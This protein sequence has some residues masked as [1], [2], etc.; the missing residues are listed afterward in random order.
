[1][2]ARQLECGLNA[3]P[4]SSVGRLFDAVASLLGVRQRARYEAQA[5]MELEALADPAAGGFYPLAIAG[6][7]PAVL[8]PAP[9]IRAIV[10]DLRAGLPVPIIAGRFHRTLAAAIAELCGGIRVATGLR[11]V[12]LS[13]G[14]FQNVTLLA[15]ARRA[16]IRAGFDV[17]SHHVVPPNDGG[18]ALGQAAVAQARLAARD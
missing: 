17:F 14:V 13:G 8:D 7:A 5:A 15:G 10:A 18:I 16:L 6:D 9:T 12:V 1:M 2:I 11:R 4:T 3:P